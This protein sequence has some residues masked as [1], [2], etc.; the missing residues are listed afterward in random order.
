M[1]FR[2]G[3][4][5]VLYMCDCGNL[6]PITEVYLCKI[7]FA[8][9]CKTTCL[10]T[11]IDS[12]YCPGCLENLPSAEAAYNGNRC[13]NCL[14]CPVCGQGLIVVGTSSTKHAPEASVEEVAVVPET[15]V[16]GSQAN[17]EAVEKIKL[18][19]YLH[20]L[21]CR[22]SS[23]DIGLHDTANSA[24]CVWQPPVAPNAQRLKDTI[25]F[26]NQNIG[27]YFADLEAE[28]KEEMKRLSKNKNR[29]S[30]NQ[31]KFRS[32][33][34]SYLLGTPS[35]KAWSKSVSPMKEKSKQILKVPP[36]TPLKRLTLEDLQNDETESFSAI[37]A[38]IGQMQI[39]SLEQRLKNPS[40]QPELVT[41][42]FPARKHLATKRCLRCLKCG[43]TVCKP[44][45]HPLS[46]KFKV[47]GQA[48]IVVPEVKIESFPVIDDLAKESSEFVI[49]IRN[50]NANITTM[51]IIPWE[52]FEADKPVA[53]Q[54]SCAESPQG[55]ADVPNNPATEREV[56]ICKLRE[57]P[58]LVSNAEL[59]ID[60]VAY[61]NG[62]DLDPKND[63]AEFDDFLSVQPQR[64]D[65]SVVVRRRNNAMALKVRVRPKET[66]KH[67]DELVTSF[68]LQ[69]GYLNNVY[70]IQATTGEQDQ[71]NTITVKCF[72][73]LSALHISFGSEEVMSGNAVSVIAKPQLR[74]LLLSYLK[75]HLIIATVLSVATG[76][77]VKA[78]INDPRKTAYANFYKNYD[79]DV[80]YEKMKK[81]GIFQSSK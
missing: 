18:F 70:T 48:Y 7:C 55:D 3:W 32:S 35:L 77:A 59:L 24:L 71:M 9:R 80:E 56:P 68:V 5:N 57:R 11:E 1:S 6:K 81:L 43:R 52:I 33:K 49:T 22:W 42:L 72:G 28:K 79:P 23:R 13:S 41:D 14:E 21:H 66:L 58:E 31:E 63:A 8:L 46:I 54:V 51:K 45:Y 4:N 27:Q 44:E 19:H 2:V 36:L 17:A 16:Q 38:V 34:M 65:P 78:L 73:A 69:Y 62:L 12:H 53:G 61:E 30:A 50:P 60:P 37:S 40:L 15:P 64:A 29:F 39:T 47:Q 75:K 26:H 67:G 74:G 10:S 25:V 20:C 76:F